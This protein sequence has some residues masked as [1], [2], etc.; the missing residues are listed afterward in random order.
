MKFQRR[1]TAKQVKAWRPIILVK[2]ATDHYH[3]AKR[4]IEINVRLHKKN[5]PV[6]LASDT[7]HLKCHQLISAWC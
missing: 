4:A 3:P 6:K 1:T 5:C 7:I 2:T